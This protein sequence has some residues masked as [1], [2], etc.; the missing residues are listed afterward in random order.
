M[1]TFRVTLYGWVIAHDPVHGW[2]SGSLVDLVYFVDSGDGYVRP[3]DI[4][5]IVENA[6]YKMISK[7]IPGTTIRES[8]RIIVERW[9]EHL[10]VG[11]ERVPAP[12][13]REQPSPYVSPTQYYGRYG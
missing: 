5:R 10:K 9:D 6:G 11:V 4:F 3:E 12:A 8:D 1:A 7:K 13:F 2:G